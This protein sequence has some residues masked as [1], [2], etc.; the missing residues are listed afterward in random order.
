MP[1]RDLNRAV[2]SYGVAIVVLISAYSLLVATSGLHHVVYTVA[3][4]SSITVL[5]SGTRIFERFESESRN[6]MLKSLLRTGK[7]LSSRE[8]KALGYALRVLVA[9][10]ALLA[11]FTVVYALVAG[12]RPECAV[13]TVFMAAL[14]VLVYHTPRFALH[15]LA[16]QRRVDIEVELPYLLIAFRV[17]SS[18]R[19]PV[20][21]MFTVIENSDALPASARE[22]RFAKKI[23][24]LTSTSFLTAMDIACANHPSEKVRELFRRVAIATVSLGDVREVVERVFESIY[25]WFESKVAGLTEKFSVIAGSAL[26]AYLFVPVVIA[27]IAPVIGGG[28]MLLLGATLSVQVFVFFLLYGMI[29]IAYPSSL[30]VKPT[31]AL[32]LASTG[33]LGIVFALLLYTAFSY[34]L[35]LPRLEEQVL[36]PISLAAL[37]PALV[38]SEKE[39]TRASVY[40][41]FVRMASDALSFAAS[42]GENVASALERYSKKYGKGVARIARSVISSYLSDPLRKAIVR[43]APSTY[44]ASFVETLTIM[45]RLGSTPDMMKAFSSSYER[46]NMLV[47]RVKGFARTLEALLVGLSAVVGG[48]VAF[49]D[50]VYEYIAGLMKGSGYSWIHLNVFAYNP[51]MY[52]LLGTLTLLSLLLVSLFIGKVRGGSVVY[53]YRATVLMLAIYALSRYLFSLVSL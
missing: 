35:G 13:L 16:S 31:K 32:I 20:H 47:S 23:A 26:F 25:G 6:M 8:L 22:V 15:F 14:A 46:L 7:G 37:V 17:M 10:T 4:A 49:I 36:M 38:I 12:F 18:L 51:A 48:F 21:D 45:F 52:G 39:L 30:V 33:S 24:T 11:C 41:S 34:L 1:S 5:F 44:H 2:K 43:A 40:D 50:R 3:L 53:C 29:T 9:L 42:T 28:S 19:L 27:A